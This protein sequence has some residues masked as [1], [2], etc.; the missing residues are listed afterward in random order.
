MFVIVRRSL[1]FVELSRLSM[2][3]ASSSA[4]TASSFASHLPVSVRC[5]ASWSLRPSI[6][7]SG[8][9]SR[10]RRT[11]RHL[12]MA[13][14][15][16]KFSTFLKNLVHVRSC[17]ARPCAQRRQRRNAHRRPS[18]PFLPK[19]ETRNVRLRESSDLV[20][21]I[22]REARRASSEASAAPRRRRDSAAA[23]RRSTRT[24]PRLGPGL[25]EPA[26]ALQPSTSL[27]LARLQ[28]QAQ[29]AFASWM[30]SR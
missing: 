6:N 10:S 13:M 5:C 28:A 22:A 4:K 20:A 1:A 3:L 23:K 29:M 25:A 30:C 12:I 9:R 24:S 26:Q 27:R 15:T 21:V 18:G 2:R 17:R 14:W 19:T 7:C 11:K 8:G 16:F